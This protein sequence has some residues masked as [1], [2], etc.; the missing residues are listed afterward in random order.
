MS[1]KTRLGL[2]SPEE[3]PVLVD[4]FNRYPIS[5][6]IVHPRV[7][8][9]FYKVPV[10]GEVLAAALPQLRLPL[11]YNGGAV[12][13]EHCARVERKLP[14]ARALMIG[15]GLV[16]DPALAQRAK[17]GP[18]ADRD[19]LRA[20]HDELYGAY[21][22]DFSGERSTVFHMKELWGFF[23]RMFDGGE[24]LFKQIRKAQGRQDYDRAV[25]QI[26]STLPLRREAD[27]TGGSKI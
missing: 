18:G 6:L 25:E 26:F 1:V 13:A 23:S 20:F 12:C 22:R 4:I 7:R 17:G 21:L 15:Q 27:W 8:T 3:F 5:L 11:C 24:K 2:G 10:R 19:T 14:R 9:D 16:A